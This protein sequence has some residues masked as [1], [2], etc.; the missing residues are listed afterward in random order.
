MKMLSLSGFHFQ[1]SHAGP[2]GPFAF[3]AMRHPGEIESARPE[4][5]VIRCFGSGSGRA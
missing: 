1:Q 3:E 2:F 5:S 4:F